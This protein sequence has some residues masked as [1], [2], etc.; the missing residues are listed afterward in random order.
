M[1][2]ALNVALKYDW[3]KN[4]VFGKARDQVMKMSGGLY[5]APLRVFFILLIDQVELY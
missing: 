1:D 5:P 2:K 3:V 4:K